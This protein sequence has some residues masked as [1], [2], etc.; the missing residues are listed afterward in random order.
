VSDGA[1]IVE[2]AHS[3]LTPA[4]LAQID[5]IFFEASGRSFPS[6]AER[7][8]FRERWLGR[9]LH[10]GTDI[11]LLALDPKGAAAGYLVGA[12][13]DPAE[14]ERFADIGYF[15][16]PFRDLCRR[17][18]A[19]LHINLAPAFR[20]RG[21]GACLIEAFVARAATG[22]RRHAGRDR[23]IR[24]QHALLPALRICRARLM[25]LERTRGRPPC[26]GCRGA[27]SA[28]DRVNFELAVTSG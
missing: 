2:V 7:A 6:A 19:H 13:Q 14:Q 3:G 28:H 8:A 9:Y 16:G 21:L 27:R 17:Y 26:Q 10:G 11:L 24:P 1:V 22:A 5:T 4:Q 23:Q 18:P 20:N 25:P 15:R 12:L